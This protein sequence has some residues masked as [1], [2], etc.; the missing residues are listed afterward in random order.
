MHRRRH[1]I[2]I[3]RRDARHRDAPVL[4]DV[5]IIANSSFSWWSAWLNNK[6][7]KTI[8]AP[9]HWFNDTSIITDDLIP[10]SW[11]KI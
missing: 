4:C 10:K 2:D 8:F 3:A 1:I 5:N 9:K 6:S 11:N 7:D